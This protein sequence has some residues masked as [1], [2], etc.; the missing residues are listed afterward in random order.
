[1]VRGAWT[2]AAA[3]AGVLLF[4]AL[5]VIRGKEAWREGGSSGA[6]PT[7]PSAAVACVAG[8]LLCVWAAFASV[9]LPLTVRTGSTKESRAWESSIYRPDF[10]SFD[11]RGVRAGA[12]TAGKGKAKA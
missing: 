12:R 3:G 5:E 10:V 11:H 8:Y 1:M 6:F 9:G 7:P 2:A 4:G